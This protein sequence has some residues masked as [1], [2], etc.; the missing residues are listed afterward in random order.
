MIGFNNNL[1]DLEEKM[2]IQQAY[3]LY[4]WYLSSNETIKSLVYYDE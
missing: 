4:S 1:F 3:P 2:N